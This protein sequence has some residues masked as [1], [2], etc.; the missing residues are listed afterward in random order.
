MRFGIGQIEQDDPPAAMTDRT[1]D[2]LLEVQD[3]RTYFRV[4]GH[5]IRAVDG[6]SFRVPRGRI[7]AIVGESGCGKSVTAYSVMRLIQKPGAIVGGRIV[8]H[9]KG[10]PPLDVTALDEKDPRLYELRGGLVSMIFQEPMTALSP[11]HTVGNQICEAIRLHQAVT[12]AEA[13]ARAAAMLAKVGIPAAA[14]RLRQYPHEMSGGMRQRVVIAMA[15]VCNPELLIADEPTT[16]VDVTIQA[17][18]L[19]L[20]RGLQRD[21]HTSV[22]LITHDLGVVAQTAEEVA[23]MYLGRIIEQADIRPLM[24]DPRHPY[25][26][27]LL[28]S[29]PSLSRRGRRLP[30]I[31]GS[32]P[33]L[34]EVPPG[35]PFHPRCPYVQKGLCDVGDPPP[36]QAMSDGRLV[37]CARAEDVLAQEGKP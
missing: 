23:V 10:R 12:S 8:L 7:V 9:P 29:L 4:D 19:E 14:E 15:L 31:A 18:I 16:A 25:T 22:L 28:H 11:V 27:G 33:S 20:I 1:D 36:M 2:I 6:A 34:K 5:E 24:R 21:L 26:R 37:A 17:Q 3:L 30:S 35:C 32:V 13:E